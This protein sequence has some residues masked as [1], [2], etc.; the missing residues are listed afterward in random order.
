M[1]YYFSFKTGCNE[2]T[3]EII[4]VSVKKRNRKKPPQALMRNTNSL[5]FRD[6]KY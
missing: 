2:N 5:A 4:S 6:G 3:P 1:N